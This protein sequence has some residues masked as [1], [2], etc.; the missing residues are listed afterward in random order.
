MTDS[1]KTKKEELIRRHKEK[2]E[3]TTV[4]QRKESAKKVLD[5]FSQFRDTDLSS[6]K[7]KV[8]LD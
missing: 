3:N 8:I 6:M 4:E 1:Q 2:M 5:F 7:R